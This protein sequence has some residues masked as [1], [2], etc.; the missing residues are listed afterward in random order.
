MRK[1]IVSEFLTV[2]GVMQAPGHS[3]EDRRGG[4]E[5]G[6]WQMGYIDEVGGKAISEGI[7]Q[8][9]GFLLG[10]KTYELFAAYWPTARADEPLAGTMNSLPKYVASRTLK[11]PLEWENSTLLKGDLVQ[12]VTKLKEQSGGDLLVIGSGDLVQSLMQQGLVDQYQLMVHPVVLGTGMRLF[13]EGS[14]MTALRLAD[15][16]TTGTG[17]LFLTYQPT[18]EN[19]EYRP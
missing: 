9:G 8:S 12:D 13:R 5:H 18:G 16:K 15:T 4:F 17:V 7:E 11:E 19:V 3:D 6:G 2:D 14:P 1:V 10:R